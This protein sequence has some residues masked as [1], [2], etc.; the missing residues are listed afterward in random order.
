MDVTF[1]IK[2]SSSELNNYDRLRVD[3]YLGQAITRVGHQVSMGAT[4][5]NILITLDAEHVSMHSERVIQVG[6]WTRS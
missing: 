2:L 1:T 4:A 3:R 6:D 5:G